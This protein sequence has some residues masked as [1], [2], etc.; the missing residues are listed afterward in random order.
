VRELCARLGWTIARKTGAER[1][2][3]EPLE[4]DIL[5]R[6]WLLAGLEAGCYLQFI[7]DNL[8]WVGAIL[9]I[10]HAWTAKHE[11]GVHVLTREVYL[12][13]D[14]P[15]DIHS[16]SDAWKPDRTHLSTREVV[17]LSELQ[18]QMRASYAIKFC[19][20]AVCTNSRE[21]E[22][23]VYV[24][25]RKKQQL[26]AE[27]VE[28]TRMDLA[29]RPTPHVAQLNCSTKFW[30]GGGPQNVRVMGRSFRSL[31]VSPLLCQE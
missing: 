17:H 19:A 3:F 8:D 24:K 30:A 12:L 14:L 5:R 16:R 1:R 22:V 11:R 15:A 28:S 18:Q 10:A 23:E 6:R 4:Q 13:G 31:A 27:E 20:S 9:R 21:S 2:L 25:A 7:D 29:S 26:T